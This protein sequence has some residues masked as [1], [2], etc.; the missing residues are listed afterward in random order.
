MRCPAIDGPDPSSRIKPTH[1]SPTRLADREHMIK[2][3]KWK[4]KI[5]GAAN[6]LLE[7]IKFVKD[8]FG[9]GDD[10]EEMVE[11]RDS[12]GNKKEIKAS[13]LL[14]RMKGQEDFAKGA[15]KGKDGS[16]MTEDTGTL[17]FEEL[18]A[19]D[20]HDN[21]KKFVT[22]AQYGHTIIKSVGYAQ[23]NITNIG[24]SPRFEVSKDTSVHDIPNMVVI[25][26]ASEE[27]GKKT[28]KFELQFDFDKKYLHSVALVG[29]WELDS[30]EAR[31]KELVLPAVQL[32]PVLFG[33][34]VRDLTYYSTKL[35][36]LLIIIGTVNFL[37]SK[38][39]F[40][41]GAG[42]RAKTD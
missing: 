14:G 30:N 35:G 8:Q 19:S 32:E 41:D 18:K 40:G 22:L 20:E 33:Y 31:V 12:D 1:S 6:S 23:G 34:R 38:Y 15:G 26:V 7:P 24:T 3:D 2:Q 28:E 21:L 13:E 29:G 25:A 9:L 11:I 42:E 5:M 10:P 39:I 17:S 37:S 36:T 4:D 16:T 27:S